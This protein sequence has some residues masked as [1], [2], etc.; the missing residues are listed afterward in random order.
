MKMVEDDVV[1]MAQVGRADGDAA[2]VAPAPPIFRAYAKPSPPFTT[3]E[4]PM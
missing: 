2:L 4:S 1:A 3:T